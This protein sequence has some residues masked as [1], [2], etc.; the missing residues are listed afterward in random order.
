MSL[1][2]DILA[3]KLRVFTRITAKVQLKSIKKGDVSTSLDE[4]A[5]LLG[6]YITNGILIKSQDDLLD[7]AGDQNWYLP[8]LDNDGNTIPEDVEPFFVKVNN[9]KVDGYTFDE[10]FTPPRIYGFANN[11]MQEIKVKII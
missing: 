4:L 1:T 9:V 7:N 10:T 8:Y 5:D 11:D 6:T 3:F 2:D